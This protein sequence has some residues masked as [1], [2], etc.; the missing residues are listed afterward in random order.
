MNAEYLII[1]DD[2]ECQKIEHICEIMPDIG[3]AI[4]PRTFGVETVRLCNAARFVVSADE[5][6]AMG[7][8]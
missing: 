4:F 7:V 2:T 6:H 1:D 5:M 3:V 8:S